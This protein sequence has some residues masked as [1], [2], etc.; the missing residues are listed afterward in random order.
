MQLAKGDIRS[1]EEDSDDDE[2]SDNSETDEGGEG[3][4]AGTWRAMLMARVS[5]QAV[6]LTSAAREWAECEQVTEACR[7]ITAIYSFIF[8]R[9]VLRLHDASLPFLVFCTDVC[10]PRSSVL[11]AGC[12]NRAAGDRARRRDGR[13]SRPPDPI[14][15]RLE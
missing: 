15:A 4:P 12:D 14:A 9:G 13:R 7:A 8:R 10:Q 6:Q 5:D 1:A 3:L 11:F 2:D